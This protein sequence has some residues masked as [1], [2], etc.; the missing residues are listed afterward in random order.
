MSRIL[1]VHLTS[2]NYAKVNTKIQQQKKKSK[3]HRVS[4]GDDSRIE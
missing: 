1:Y 4:T 2:T 3:A